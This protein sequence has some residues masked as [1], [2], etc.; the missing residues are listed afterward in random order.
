MRPLTDLER[1][2]AEGISLTELLRRR[3]EATKHLTDPAMQ[4]FR[5]TLARYAAPTP[6]TK[7]T[8]P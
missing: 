8:T 2:R 1:C 5:D 3:R 6:P 4:A 7:G